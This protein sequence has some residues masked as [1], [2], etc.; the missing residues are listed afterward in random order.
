MHLR[1][2]GSL[3]L[4]VRSETQRLTLHASFRQTVSVLHQVKVTQSESK[5]QD[6]LVQTRNDDDSNISV[7]G[8]LFDVSWTADDPD[9]KLVFN[10]Q[11]NTSTVSEEFGQTLVTAS[12]HVEAERSTVISTFEDQE[13]I[14][15]TSRNLENNNDCYAVTYFV[16]K[17][18]EIYNLTTTVK[19]IEVRIYEP[20]LNNYSN[21]LGLD[22]LED[23]DDAIRQEI[24]NCTKLLPTVGETINDAAM[25][26][27]PTDG[28]VYEP[29]LA[30]CSSCEP[31]KIVEAEIRLDKAKGKSRKHCLEAELLQLEVQRRKTLLENGDLTPFTDTEEDDPAPDA[32]P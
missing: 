19:S 4:P 29:E 3:R 1:R 13:N 5:F 25:I 17:V 31:M 30:H 28:T 21:W 22:E 15:T 8:K 6:V 12:Q 2:W 10:L 27:I 16:R 23:L 9:T 32:S 14:E 24:L 7:G 18:N 26:T 20:R 11:A